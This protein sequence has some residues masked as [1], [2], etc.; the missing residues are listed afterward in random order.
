MPDLREINKNN[1]IYKTYSN[2]L[3]SPFYDLRNIKFPEDS[4]K[5][6]ISKYIDKSL[7]DIRKII[8]KKRKR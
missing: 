4:K 8:N 7:L 6:I 3:T 5:N 1:Q 2:G